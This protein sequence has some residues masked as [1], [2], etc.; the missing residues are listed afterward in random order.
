MKK[1]ICLLLLITIL[2]TGLI[3]CSEDKTNSE[4]KDNSSI[5]SDEIN[6]SEEESKGPDYHVE[7]YGEREFIISTTWGEDNFISEFMY[8]E[9]IEGKYEFMSDAVNEAIAERN[10][11][12]EKAL[13]IKIVE[14]HKKSGRKGGEY[15]TYVRNQIMNGTE[16]AHIISPSLYDLGV[17]AAEGMLY[18]LKE[19]ENIKIDSSRWDQK[20]NETM[21]V[22]DKLYFTLGDVGIYNKNATPMV[23]FN[24]KLADI[25]IK[26]DLYQI[27]KDGKWTFDKAY[28]YAKLLSTD[29]NNDNI[30]DYFDNVGWAGQNDDGWNFFFASGEKIAST[31]ATGKIALTMNTER[32]VNVIE[33]MNRMFHD[34]DHYISANDYFAAPYSFA[35]PSYDA[36]GAAFIEGRILFFSDNLS[37]IHRFEGMPDDFGILPVPKYDDTQD[38]YYSL[39]NPWTGNAFAIPNILTTD[40]AEFAA[41]CFDA[42]AYYSVDSVAVE[43]IDRTLKYQKISDEGS[44]DMLNIILKSRGC[45]FGIIY[46]LG[47]SQNASLPT[48][49]HRLIENPTESF[50]SLYESMEPVAKSDLEKVLESYK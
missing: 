48:L 37:F 33:K 30:I 25:Y 17:L 31:D 21:T 29:T 46:E 35:F 24:K 13:N 45:D 23:A 10:N 7:D 18:N 12:V 2:S 6:Q 15:L 28:E 32:A 22:N 50:S 40:D 8:N 47:S 20:F 19:L 11:K 27:V 26:D 9:L 34:D 1:Y 43:Y 36:T 39:I 4:L 3:S 44:I 16:E 14:K 42:M 38:E 49:L 5:S 41:A